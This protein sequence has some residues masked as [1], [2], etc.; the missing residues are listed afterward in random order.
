M[1][2][3][4]FPASLRYQ[5]RAQDDQLEMLR[6]D[7]RPLGALPRVGQESI[8]VGAFVVREA[9]PFLAL[10]CPSSDP[11]LGNNYYKYGQKMFTSHTKSPLAKF[12]SRQISRS[13]VRASLLPIFCMTDQVMVFKIC[14]CSSQWLEKIS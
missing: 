6:Q 4:S 1:R 7:G 5:S 11:S 2:L 3:V 8:P 9:S 14:K 10:H 12:T 13:F